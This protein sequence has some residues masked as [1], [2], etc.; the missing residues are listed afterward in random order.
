MSSRS[1]VDVSRVR[2]SIRSWPTSGSRSRVC[3]TGCAPLTST[4]DSSPAPRQRRTPSYVGRRSGSAGAGEGGP[5]PCSG[6]S[7]PGE[8]AG[9]MMYP[10]VREP[11]AGGVPGAV[12]CRVS[13]L[14]RQHDGT[15]AAP[16]PEPRPPHRRPPAATSPWPPRPRTHA[17]SRGGDPDAQVT[18]SAHAWRPP[19]PTSMVVPRHPPDL[20]CC[21]DRLNLRY[22]AHASTSPRYGTPG[23]SAPW[24]KSGPAPTTRPWSPSSRPYRRMWTAGAGPPDWTCGSRS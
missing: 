11:G 24:G 18:A 19:S 9:K 15:T 14:A 2:R 22:L 1:L 23:S 21:D 7:V 3:A 8:S 4:T 20:G 16:R 12:T 10:L 17:P 13:K 6:V 5:S